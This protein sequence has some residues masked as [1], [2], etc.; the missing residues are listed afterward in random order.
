M[1][2]FPY[3][4]GISSYE[5]RC[6][7]P[8]F[9]ANATQVYPTGLID[10]N[11]RRHFEYTPLYSGTSQLFT[12]D[13]PTGRTFGGGYLSSFGFDSHTPTSSKNPT[14]V[15][16]PD[17]IFLLSDVIGSSGAAPGA[18][19][20]KIG[21][22]DVGFPEFNYWPPDKIGQIPSYRY[23]FV[24]G[25]NLED[26]GIV[27]LLR[28]QY[29]YIIAFV[30]AELPI[31]STSDG[32]VDGISGQV[33]RLFGLIPKDTLGN[34]QDTQ[35]FGATKKEGKALFGQL[36]KNLKANQHTGAAFAD[37]YTI[38]PS[39]SFEIPPYPQEKTFP[40]LGGGKVRVLWYYLN[41]N[42]DWLN[43]IKNHDVRNILAGSGFS[44]FPNYNTVF[45]NLGELL[46]LT[47]PQ[48]Q[49]IADMTAYS[50]TDGRSAE[51]LRAFHKEV[52][53]RM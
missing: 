21:L 22:T 42:D 26:T 30:N 29:P 37:T 1:S 33:S 5:V 32:A 16:T 38:F 49:L 51:T 24:D 20:D 35:V 43:A 18:E 2:A 44:N 45:Q 40:Y 39:N 50:I 14:T 6:D 19:L 34:D 15:T 10:N 27:A 11:I 12:N 28:R 46:L 31:G 4:A 17:P 7:R 3:L 52:T 25:G 41:R 23:S 47:T 53:D 36:V 9:I 48:I 13:L 8:Y